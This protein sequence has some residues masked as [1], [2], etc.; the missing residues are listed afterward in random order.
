MYLSGEGVQQSDAIGSDWIRK[1]SYFCGVA[2]FNM[3]IL[4]ESGRGVRKDQDMADGWFEKARHQGSDVERAVSKREEFIKTN[5]S[6]IT[7]AMV[8]LGV[9]GLMYVAE[10]GDVTSPEAQERQR[11][12]D[13][14]RRNNI[15]EMTIDSG[16]LGP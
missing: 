1:A 4:Y 15:W 3:G 5:R 9:A 12:A 11:E 8:F 2:A 13:Q 14:L 6:E 16:V 10:T 7:A